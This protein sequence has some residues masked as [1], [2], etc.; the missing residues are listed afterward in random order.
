VS[1]RDIRVQAINFIASMAEHVSREEKEKAEI[2]RKEMER[3]PTTEKTP[4]LSQPA[5]SPKYISIVPQ[6]ALEAFLPAIVAN[7]EKVKTTALNGIVFQSTEK[8]GYVRTQSWA[9]TLQV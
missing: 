1:D 9:T 2:R 7:D 6:L 3:A 5:L 4:T 8:D